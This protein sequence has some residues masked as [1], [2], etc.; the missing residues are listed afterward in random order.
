MPSYEFRD[1]NTGEI[2]EAYM[3]ISEY[4]E[5]K[6]N[7]PHHERYFGVAPKVIGGIDSS[8]G[9]KLPEGFKDKLRDIK[10]KH[11]GAGG[12]DHLL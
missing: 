7:N 2:F 5:Y 4:G 8:S 3:K 6:K 10:A 9:G 12:V 11:P 1:I